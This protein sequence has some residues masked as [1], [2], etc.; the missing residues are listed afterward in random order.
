MYFLFQLFRPPFS[1]LFKQNTIK[2]YHIL[3]IFAT[4][5]LYKLDKSAPLLLNC[6]YGMIEIEIL[7][8]LERNLF[9]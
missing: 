1:C 9:L 8:P 7:R 3:L 4:V 6:V 5:F 2:I